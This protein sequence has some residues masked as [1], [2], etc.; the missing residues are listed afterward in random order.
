MAR[1]VERR[2]ALLQPLL[3]TD[4]NIA[5][6][7]SAIRRGNVDK[8]MRT[9]ARHEWTFPMIW[10]CT[11]DVSL[12]DFVSVYMCNER[13]VTWMLSLRSFDKICQTVARNWPSHDLRLCLK[14]NWCPLLSLRLLR[15]FG[16]VNDDIVPDLYRSYLTGDGRSNA[17]VPHLRWI[18][19]IRVGPDS[20]WQHT[21]TSNVCQVI[22]YQKGLSAWTC[23]L[24]NVDQY[25]CAKVLGIRC[26]GI[27]R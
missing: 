6:L 11:L 19:S 7:R 22:R 13:V 15:I 23:R 24:S 25:V 27:R 16:C 20:G 3:M 8:L 2:G 17:T 10:K 12:S 5:G 4:P 14:R 9:A 18:A 26:W 21:L 1:F